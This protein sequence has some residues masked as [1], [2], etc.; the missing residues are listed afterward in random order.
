M[1][2]NAV[3]LTGMALFAVQCV[4]KKAQPDAEP[5]S[6][7]NWTMLFDGSGTDQW[8]DTK[9]EQFP[10]HGWVIEGEVLTVLGKTE[11][12]PGGH[13]IISKKQYGNFELELEVR[14][15]EGANSGIK[16]LVIDNFPGK[17]GNF[18][19]LE[20]Q[21]IDNERHPDAQKGR[22]GNHKMAALYDMIAP[23]ENLPIHPP[24]AWNTVRIML[25]GPQVKHWLNG[26]KV[27]EFDRKS[28][29][30]RELVSLSKYKD[31]EKFGEMDKGHILLQ[32]H[33]N[34]VSFRN[35]K[36]RTW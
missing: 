13:D 31:L 32:G 30:F 24:G 33:G 20:Y 34:D 19:G 12:E 21:L 28:L 11:D 26:E 23:P 6:E 5:V 22:D 1:K 36:I 14:L 9:S 29:A 10:E 15:T 27:L 18:L 2:L 25:D 4:N 7:V 3:I 17:E 16:Y 8:R 35:I